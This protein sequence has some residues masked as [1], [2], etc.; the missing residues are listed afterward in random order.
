MKNS[1]LLILS[2][3]FITVY[4]VAQNKTQLGTLPT[5][6][7]AKEL[8]NDW[9]LTSKI[10]NRL[11]FYNKSGLNSNKSLDFIHTDVA[12]LGSKKVGLSNQLSAGLLIRLGEFIEKRTIQQFNIVT[13]YYKFQLAHR[14]AADQTFTPNEANSYRFRYRL[15]YSNPLSGNEI[16][17]N[18]FYVK[19]SIESL[20]IYE[21]KT[22][23]LELRVVPTLGYNFK[24]SNK[25]ELGLDSR[26]DGILLDSKRQRYFMVVNYYVKI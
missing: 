9:Q 26:L 22:E 18:E 1:V 19:A 20:L 16:N 25:I 2:F 24:N 15:S 13:D 17:A 21:D 7:I 10:E 5:L 14:F 6:T 11:F 8:K 23:D 4:S 3:I 12:F